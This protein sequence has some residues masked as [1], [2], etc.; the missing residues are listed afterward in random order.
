[1]SKLNPYA[2]LYV[3]DEALAL[4][5]FE[6][7]FSE[8]F[9]IYTA[10]S[11]AEGWA[12]IQK[13][14]ARIGVLMTDQRMPGQTGVQLLE[15][16][17]HAYPQ[18]VRILVTAY[19][20]LESAVAGVNEGAIYRYL[21]KPWDAAE[22]RITLLRALEF[23]TVLRERDQL[24]RE[25]LSVLQQIVLSDAT[26]NLGVLAAGLSC[27]F[28]HALRAASQFI[29]ALP[30]GHPEADGPEMSRA[31]FG[32]NL[33]N[34]IKKASHHTFHVSSLMRDLAGEAGSAAPEPR[35]LASLLGDTKSLSK[36]D[37]IEL[38]IDPALPPLR[39]HPKQIAKLFALLVSNLK[40][41]HPNDSSLC[42]EAHEAT[43]AGAKVI[44]ILFSDNGPDWTPEQRARFFAP[45]S[46][47]KNESGS[48]G[49]DLAVCFFIVHHHG[50]R[51]T[52]SGKAK[53]R[54]AID[55]PL[56]PAESETSS[57]QQSRLDQLF[58]RERS[59]EEFL[60]RPE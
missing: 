4:K 24:V 38:K 51:I 30:E 40:A 1:M 33:E 36:A 49:L 58:Q 55:L 43:D 16:V 10:A 29:A 53:A 52:V 37:A 5:Y 28:R 8:D 15:R 31:A 59:W 56:E 46:S 41:L 7:G 20:S 35:P 13:H 60:G 12:L 25:K 9:H 26:K 22:V 42:I 11:A 50:G 17:R 18:I 21:S 39:A 54:V 3:D 48:L 14:H 45:F 44:R 57:W 6:K 34:L 32:S 23:Y 19:S 27:H 2:V 47:T